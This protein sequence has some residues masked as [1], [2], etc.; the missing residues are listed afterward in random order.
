ML[1]MVVSKKKRG[2]VIERWIKD[3]KKGG[4]YED[5]VWSIIRSVLSYGGGLL[6]L[7][8]FKENWIEH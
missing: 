5:P 4:C 3:G 6:P 2:E 1:S 7:V 8:I